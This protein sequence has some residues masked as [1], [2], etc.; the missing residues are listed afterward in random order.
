MKFQARAAAVLAVMIFSV[1]LGGC[2]VEKDKGAAKTYAS[3]TNI[4]HTYVAGNV[5]TYDLVRNTSSG[6]STGTLEVKW[7][8]TDQI[9]DPFD[10]NQ[11]YSVLKET[12]NIYYSGSTDP[13][14]SAV[15]YLEQDSSGL[16][17]GTIFLRAI[18]DPASTTNY[19]LS[20]ENNVPPG[21]L[22]KVEIFRSP[23][24]LGNPLTI[25]FN[26]MSGCSGTSCAQS[27]GNLYNSL[28]AVD[29]PEVVSGTGKGTFT[30][31]YKAT[32]AGSLTPVDQ[33][34]L[35]F[36]DFLDICHVTGSATTS[37]NGTLY[38]V[39]EV[40]VI[41]MINTCQS[42]INPSETYI[43]TLRNTTIALPP[44]TN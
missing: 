28:E 13:D 21:N 5:I 40:G 38:I 27:V 23:I 31:V 8:A 22:E 34:P 1:S 16:T 11:R 20:S 25:D 9:Q 36:F 39:P 30:N 17:N 3:T 15:R 10:S 14:E 7:E 32:Y 33:T 19:W 35:P 26:V 4:L 41:K 18:D 43:A 12:T 24:I 6:T 42:G 2:L 37:H 44:L 29:Y